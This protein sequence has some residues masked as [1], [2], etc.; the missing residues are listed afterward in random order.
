M[1]SSKRRSQTNK[2][3]E[4][5]GRKSKIFLFILLLVTVVIIGILSISFSWQQADKKEGIDLFKLISDRFSS[6]SSTSVR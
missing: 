2:A 5:A 6:F 3:A 4:F 1:P